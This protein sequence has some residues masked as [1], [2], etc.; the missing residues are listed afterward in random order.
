MIENLFVIFAP[1]LG[2]NHLSNL[3]SLTP[4]FHKNFDINNYQDGMKNAHLSVLTNLNQDLILK[5]QEEL[6]GNSNVLCG[7]LGEYLWLQNNQLDHFFKNRRFAVIEFPEKN[8]PAW[9]RLVN[10]SSYYLNEYFFYEQKTLYS[11]KYLK[12]L[13]DEHDY[14]YIN[15]ENIFTESV[16]GIVNFVEQQLCTTID[17]EL[18]Q[19]LHTIWFQNL[20]KYHGNT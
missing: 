9:N 8:S 2:G 1:G 10:Y 4:R 5:H 7:H 11:S 13:F 6:L 20:F 18:A 19:K 15:S 16:N 3:I 17:A 12:L 14:F